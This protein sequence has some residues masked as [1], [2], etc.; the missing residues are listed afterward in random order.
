MFTMKMLIKRRDRHHQRRQASKLYGCQGCNNDCMKL[1]FLVVADVE[2]VGS[3]YGYSLKC[4]VA[5]S[6]SCCSVLL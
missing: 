4:V 5:Y 6:C 1:F 3:F 2:L